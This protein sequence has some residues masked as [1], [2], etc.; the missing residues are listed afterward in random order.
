MVVGGHIATG[1]YAA[2]MKNIRIFDRKTR[3][4]NIVANMTFQRWY[5]TGEFTMTDALCVC[6]PK[7]L[8][9]HRHNTERKLPHHAATL[10]PSGKIVIMGGT[11]LPG[12][13]TGQNKKYEIWDPSNPTATPQA[14]LQSPGMVASTNDVSS[15]CTCNT[16]TQV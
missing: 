9:V 11:Q 15:V 16:S 4:F 12:S 13:G 1:G 3:K 8:L 10:L 7:R 6:E 2:G 5:P 14:I